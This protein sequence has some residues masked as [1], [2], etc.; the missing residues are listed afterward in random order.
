MKS[1]DRLPLI[2]AVERHLHKDSV[3]FH[4][5]GHKNGELLHGKYQELLRY[6]V[7]ELTGLDDLHAPSEAIAEAQILLAE[8]YGAE[9]SYFLVNGSTVGNLAMILGSC[10]E[11]DRVLVQRNCHKSVLNGLKLANV[12]PVF[13]HPEYD[14]ETATTTGISLGTLE[15]ALTRYP[16]AKAI[17]LTYPTYYGMV[18]DLQSIID[19]AHDRGVKV[20]IDEAHG[21]HFAYGEPFPHSSLEMGADVVVQ[22]AHKTLPAMTMG[23]FLHI[24]RNSKDGDK[25]GHYL[26]MLQ[27]SSPSYPIMCSLDYARH[28]IASYTKEDLRC[29][30]L[31]RNDFIKNLRESGF[32]VIESGDPLK[33]LI[34]LQGLSGFQLQDRLEEEGVYPELA[35]PYQVLFILPLIKQGRTFPFNQVLEKMAKVIPGKREEEPYNYEKNNK[36][37]ELRY[38][39]K[40]IEQ[41]KKKW[42]SIDDAAGQTAGEMLIPYP[43]GIPLLYPG[44][45][46]TGESVSELK[47]LLE[48]GARFQGEHKLKEGKVSIL[49]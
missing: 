17:V 23:S 4:V 45:E 42:I 29:F 6:D 39:Y 27:S 40:D 43:P 11:G 9:K 35:D 38:S 33:L 20:L 44:E 28:F 31:E 46:I 30:L 1:Q 21:A 19:L 49:E 47:W 26:S 5:P 2:E 13:L 37:T 41:K 15:E 3:S 7:T 34:R 8:C 32:T 22:S 14:A 16:E 12:Q 18:Y 36:I 10:G 25:I 48:H 24:N